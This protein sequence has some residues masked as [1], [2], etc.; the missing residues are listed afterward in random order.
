MLVNVPCF[1]SAFGVVFSSPSSALAKALS[2][3]SD[4]VVKPSKFSGLG[5]TNIE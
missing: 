3:E 4:I 5:G 1:V 2:S